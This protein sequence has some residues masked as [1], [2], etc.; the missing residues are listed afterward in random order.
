M[1]TKRTPLEGYQQKQILLERL[2]SYFDGLHTLERGAHT[3]R[4][5]LILYV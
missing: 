2:E 4:F 3:N 1:D 5:K